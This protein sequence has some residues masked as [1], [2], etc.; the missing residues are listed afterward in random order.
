MTKISHDAP[1]ATVARAIEANELERFAY[2]SQLPG[3]DFH[4]SS[5]LTWFLTGIPF[6]GKAEARR[7]GVGVG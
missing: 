3:G 2:V 5:P 7:K 4:R 6:Y 1:T